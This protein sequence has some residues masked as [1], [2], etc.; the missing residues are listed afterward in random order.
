MTGCTP[1]QFHWLPSLVAAPWVGPALYRLNTSR[2]VLGLMLRRHVW[3]APTLLTPERIRE[4]QRLARRPGARFASVAFVSG[5]LGS[6]RGSHLV[7][8]A[9]AVAPMPAAGGAGG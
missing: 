3:V 2:A 1:Q 7:A 6:D 8:A 4:Q 5:G 9:G